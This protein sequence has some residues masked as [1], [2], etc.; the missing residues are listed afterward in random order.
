[1]RPLFAL[2]AFVLLAMSQPVPADEIVLKQGDRERKIVGKVLVTA[3]DGGII[4]LAPDGRIWPIRPAELV[5]HKPGG[6]EFVPL[7]HQQLIAELKQELPAGF[8]FHETKHYLICYNTSDAYAQWCGG[9]FERLYGAFTNYWTE[10]EMPLVEPTFPMVAVVFADRESFADYSRAE[11]GDAVSAI[12]GYYSFRS[13]HMTMYD[14]TGIEALRK[15]GDKGKTADINQFLSQPQ[16]ERTVATIIHEATHQIAHNCGLQTRYASNPM[17]FSE[18][19]ALYF[20]TP[21]LK[22]RKGWRNIGA[23]NQF[24]MG[25]FQKYLARRPAGALATIITDDKAFRDAQKSADAYAESWAL[26]YF[27]MRARPKQ[28]QEYLAMLSKKEVA[29]WDTAETRLTEFKKTFGELAGLEAD[30][31]RFMRKVRSN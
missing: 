8:R 23:V 31:L 16:A 10:R 21:D 20:E 3:E 13:N 7:D 2:L 11:L 17:W 30:Y 25:N 4:A 15:P 18:G 29:A 12:I 26:T 22:S 14:L 28:Y 24:Q 9:L 1:M 19:M 5:S 6:P 27:L